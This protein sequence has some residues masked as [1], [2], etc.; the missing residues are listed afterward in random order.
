MIPRL[1]I[2][3]SDGSLT[4]I[5]SGFANSRPCRRRAIL[6]FGLI[7]CSIFV[8][9]FAPPSASA[10]TNA[11]IYAG[12]SRPGP[13][14]VMYYSPSWEPVYGWVVVGWDENSE[15]IYEWGVASYEYVLWPTYFSDTDGDGLGDDED[16]AAGTF[17]ADGDGLGDGFEVLY[18]G[19]SPSNA[20][21]LYG[22]PFND[23]QVFF[24]YNASNYDADGDGL[25][26]N[27]EAN[28]YTSPVD[29]DSDDDG[30]SDYVEY[31]LGTNPNS[32]ADADGDSLTD[33]NEVI[34]YGTDP[35]DTDTDDDGLGDGAELTYYYTDPTLADTD[36]DTVSDGDE[37]TNTTDPNDP[38]SY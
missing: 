2:P 20:Y 31:V 14:N 26:N 34:T 11:E 16:Q 3:I 37:I 22:T 32:D 33:A 28:F 24:G 29:S 17:D 23:G 7:V 19:S 36:G 9:C 25:T 15:P 18:L 6:A 5:P 10:Q 21:S 12:W 1:I 35:F 8:L 38:N 4:S 27:D 30:L 13:Y